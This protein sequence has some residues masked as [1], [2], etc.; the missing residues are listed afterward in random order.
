MA[1]ILVVD[2][3]EGV[4]SFVGRALSKDG[5]TVLDAGDGVE[6]LEVLARKPADLLIVDVAMPR[7][8]GLTLIHQL[9]LAGSSVKILATA[10]IG[11]VGLDLAMERGADATIAKPF[12][13]DELIAAVRSLLERD[14]TGGNCG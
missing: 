1:I 8:D 11:P 7:M 3:E 5:H 10:G 2:D 4:R 9:R 6:A 12:R 13:V 14:G